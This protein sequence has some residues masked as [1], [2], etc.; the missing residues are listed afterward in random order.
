M[1]APSLRADSR[2][3][4]IA[5]SATDI[6]DLGATMEGVH[7]DTGAI[8][9]LLKSSTRAGLLQRQKITN[10]NGHAIQRAAREVPGQ[11]SLP[12]SAVARGAIARVAPP[13][14]RD[15]RGRFVAGAQQPAADLTPVVKA[16]DSLT[17][18]QAEQRAEEKRAQ[19][20]REGRTEAAPAGAGRFRDS[21]GRFGSGVS[22]GGSDRGENGGMSRWLARA[23]P[24]FSGISRTTSDLDK[25]DP[26]VEAAKEAGQLIATP[27]K[28][29]GAVAKVAG[30]GFNLGPA[31]DAAVPWYRRMWQELRQS[32][33]QDSDF[34]LAQMRML[35]EIER[36][37]GGGSGG[38]KPGLLGGLGGMLGGLLGKGGGLMG[39]LMGAG[40]GML[41]RLP[42]LGA[43]FAGGSAL[44]SIFGG[45]DPTKSAEE[46][47]KDRFT[48]AGSGIGALVGGGLGMLLGPVGA[49]VG[50]VIGDKVGELVGGWLST[51][52]WAAV[53]Q[54][55]T[56]AWDSTV[57]FF[58]DTWNAATGKLSELAKTVSDAWKSIIAGAKSFLK[59]KFGID[60]DAITAKAEALAAPV[61]DATKKAAAPVVDAAK[62]GYEAAKG[63][64]KAAVDY[65]KERVEKMAA[66]IGR[67]AGNAADAVK[68]VFGGGSKGNKAALMQ[69]A[70]TIAD[71]TERAMFMA[72]MDH[73][74]GGFRSL[75]ENVKY[76][77][78]QFLKMY[79][80]RAGITTEDQAKAILSQGEGAT[81]EAMYGGTWGAKNLGN[82]EAGDGAK[83]KGRGFTQLTG[84]ANY[85]AAAKATG[86]DL[87]NHPELA[88]DPAN[89][90]RI[91]MW[92]WRSRQ[93]LADAGKAG[94]VLATTKKINGGTNG[95]DDRK[96]KFG[97]YLAETSKP[98]FAAGATSAAAAPGGPTAPATV[99]QAAAPSALPPVA[100][101]SAPAAPPH[102]STPSVSLPA[103]P[104]VPPTAQA[105]IP[106][107]MNRKAPMQV[108]IADNRPVSR[109]LRD[110]RL[111]MIATGGLSG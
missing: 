24:A 103:A 6:H 3:F 63:G 62:A 101:V 104:S 20:A 83:F 26:T 14:E 40:K 89:A 64:A 60:I 74:S 58:R 92:Y 107:P 18:Q 70:T 34:N 96:E 99:A 95:L 77:P 46:N 79:G 22:A 75:E 23:K 19:A 31:K 27:L 84:R 91:A 28:A 102:V 65:G 1:N 61:V 106:V 111:A 69:Q 36:K 21:Q 43:L 2:G 35:K 90:A 88:S 8:L 39:G 98:G 55:I 50:G 25:V 93:G 97:K 108:T 54:Q 78:A 71:P 68:G 32:R 7:S 9:A 13:R 52:D 82:T 38:D 11:A 51:V 80:K 110:R 53:G 49:I 33:R 5:D 81:A 100:A 17:R 67:A 37:T 30:R 85:T 29:V 15:S 16:V 45:D 73:E 4:L 59:D 42:M 76:K 87:V 44:A 94:D 86:L 47:R 41:K 48:G 12:A 66:P 72:Q 105:S 10:P 109:D 57:G 56:G